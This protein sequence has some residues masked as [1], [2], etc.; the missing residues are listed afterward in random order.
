MAG[1]LARGSVQLAAFPTCRLGT[2]ISGIGQALAAYSC[3]GSRGLVSQHPAA[4][5]MRTTFPH[6][7]LVRERPSR[8]LVQR[9]ALALSMAT[10]RRGAGRGGEGRTIVV[11]GRMHYPECVVRC[12]I[13]TAWG[14][15]VKRESGASA[16]SAFNSGTAPATV[17]ESRRTFSHCAGGV[18]R[19]SSAKGIRESGDRPDIE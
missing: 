13:P 8:A 17:S 7:S 19:H 2:E 16:R 15:R 14:W 12:S 3:G 4:L 18:G 6:R 9:C 11:A 10:R 5:E 1:L